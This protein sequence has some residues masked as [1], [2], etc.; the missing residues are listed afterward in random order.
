VELNVPAE[1]V[2]VG[3][4]VHVGVADKY[5]VYSSFLG[6]SAHVAEV[7][8]AID[9]GYVG[10]EAC[11]EE[12]SYAVALAGLEELAE[13]EAAL[14]EAHAEVEE[15]PCVLVLEEDLVSSDLVDAAM[16]SELH[17]SRKTVFMVK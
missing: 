8:L 3:D 11:G 9:A 15:D 5:G 1:V 2:D 6:W 7:V 14:F 4:V 10:E 13:V 17:H 16:E 12:V